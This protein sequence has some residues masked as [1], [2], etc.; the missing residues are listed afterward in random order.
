MRHVNVPHDSNLD[1]ESSEAVK[2]SRRRFLQSAAAAAA[3]TAA[4]LARAQQPAAT[5]AP[6]PTSTTAAPLMP[7]KLTINGRAYDMQLEARTTLLDALREYASLTGTKKGCDRGQCGACTVI[8]NGRR[9]NS[10]LT[11]AVMHDGDSIVTVEGLANAQTLTLSPIQRAF[12]D[13]DAF[14]CGFCTPGQLCS[15]TALMD[16]FRA[17]DA[18][19]ATADVRYRPAQLSDDEIRERMS[20]N[21]CRCGAYPNIVA[22]VKT[23]AI[24]KA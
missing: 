13:H 7:V 14:Q 23:V 6:P 12:I 22:A 19:A 17:G 20:G 8:A 18:S 5:S 2:P 1:Q 21:I 24:N 4:P 3:V 9:I 11:L 16:E 10:C 15:A